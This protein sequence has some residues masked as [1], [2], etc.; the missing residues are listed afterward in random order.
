MTLELGELNLPGGP[1]PLVADGCNAAFSALRSFGELL[2]LA[3]A[4]ILEIDARELEVGLQPW[5]TEQ[6]LSQ[7]VFVADRLDNGAGYATRLATAELDRAFELA[8]TEIAAKWEAPAHEACDASCPDCLRSYE[9]RRLHPYLDW[10][11][12][13]DM[14][15]LASGQSLSETRWQERSATAAQNLA[16]A[17]DFEP[18]ALADLPAIRSPSTDRFVVLGHPLWST[19]EPLLAPAQSAALAAAPRDCLLSDAYS[20]DRSPDLIARFLSSQS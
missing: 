20:A 17:F 3:A 4:D 8:T 5:R 1:R 16:A 15:D 6:G 9:N 19:S 18:A 11:L 10:R 12:A 2:R 7:R 14:V 13:L